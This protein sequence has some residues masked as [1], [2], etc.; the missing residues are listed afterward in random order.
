MKMNRM[1]DKNPRDAHTPDDWDQIGNQTS[2]DTVQP[3]PD[4]RRRVPVEPTPNSAPKVAPRKPSSVNRRAAGNSLGQGFARLNGAQQERQ[5]HFAS[6]IVNGMRDARD[7][8]ALTS[9][10]SQSNDFLESMGFGRQR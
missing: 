10:L 6:A 9:E 4:K 2:P 3:P 5:E 7:R 1:K 8:D